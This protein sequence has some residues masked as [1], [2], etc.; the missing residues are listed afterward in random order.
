MGGITGL[1]RCAALAQAHGVELV[2]HQT[3]PTVGHLANLHVCAAQLHSTKPCE[4]N[5]PSTRMHAVF[6]EVPVPQ[7]GLFRLSDRP[8]LGIDFDD[9]ALAKRRIDISAKP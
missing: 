4:W 7:G 2:S 5:D 6:D 1:Q 9:A 8:G 3:Q